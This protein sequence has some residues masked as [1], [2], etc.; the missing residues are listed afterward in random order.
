MFLRDFLNEDQL[1]FYIFCVQL[2]KYTKMVYQAYIQKTNNY[3]SDA[4]LSPNILFLYQRHFHVL[5]HT[6]FLIAGFTFDTI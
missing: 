3:P 6:I 4:L 5:Q 2:K 1:K